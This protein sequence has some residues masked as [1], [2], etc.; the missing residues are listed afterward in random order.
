MVSDVLI[1]GGGLAG[2]TAAIRLSR[3]GFSTIVV[4][5]RPY[6]HHK[7][8]GE[9]VSNEVYSFL[10]REGM[11]DNLESY[12]QIKKFQLTAESGKKA[13]INLDMGGFGISRFRFDHELSLKA[14]KAGVNL[15]FDEVTDIK[16]EGK[17]FNTIL[18]KGEPI[19][20]KLV[21]SAHGKRS[22]LDQSMNREFMQQRSPWVGIKYHIHMDVPEDLIAL[23]NFPGGYCGISKV[24]DGITNLCY[25]T[26]RENLLNAKSVPELEKRIL[27]KNPFLAR[28]LSESESLFEKPMVINEVSFAS[29]NIVENGV[30]M[31]G[32]SA[33]LIA[34]LCGNG[35]AMAIHSGKIISDLLIQHYVGGKNSA[36]IEKLYRK[37]WSANFS[38]RLWMGR[39]LQAMFGKFRSSNNLVTLMRSQ[40]RFARYLI[41]KTHG[42]EL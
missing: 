14:Q 33:G 19:Q 40:P 25:L 21:L 31:I 16:R 20:S 17:D 6:P 39:N 4:E 23:H 42:R 36:E 22:R 18:L 3:A 34:P 37:E 24:E 35:M 32:D 38:R 15:V 26:K 27:A 41:N 11:V 28:I 2:L 7:V 29:K 5:K 30:F 9:Y 12:P 8:C 13:E 10:D 1:A